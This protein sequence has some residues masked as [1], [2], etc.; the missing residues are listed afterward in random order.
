MREKLRH[1]IR[2]DRAIGFVWQA[3]SKW[4]IGSA[5]VMALQGVL[6]LA[7]LYLMKLIVDAVTEAVGAP[8]PAA[9]FSRVLLFILLAGGVA[10]L[11]ASLGAISGLIQEGL[12]LTVSDRMYDRLHAKSIEVDLDYYENPQYFDTLHRAQRE[13][14]NRPTQIVNTL[15]RLGQNS[16]SLVAMAGLLFT[17][18]WAVALVLVAA[19]APGI[20]VRMKYSRVMYHW[21]RDKTPDERKAMYYN[22]ILTGNAHAKEVRLFGIGEEISDR[23]SAVRQNLRTEKLAITRKRV[24]SDF[25]AQAFGSLAV[26][27]TFAVIAYRA[28]LGAITLGDMVM[29]YQAFQRGLGY[30]RSV[31]QGVAGLYENNLF[32]SYLYEFL[33]FEPHVRNPDAPQP[34]PAQTVQG[35][36][37]A[38]VWFRYPSTEQMVLKDI[39]FA[40]EP[41]EVVALVGE[42]GSGKTTLAK[43]LCRLY[44]PTEGQIFLENISLDRFSTAA[45]RREISV[46]FQDFAKYNLSAADNIRFGHIDLPASDIE[47][48]EKAAMDAGADR[49][50]ETLHNQ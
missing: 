6:P 1:I 26:F 25:I 13:G 37:F 47:S 35:L 45:L 42:N 11:Q 19:A 36:R 16:I 40:I 14:P 49:I 15:M 4:V 12:S 39:S 50:I 22:W 8:D 30:L 41:G 32:L 2:L 48:V 23:F 9:A 3:G 44:D 18:H 29:F 20:F 10:L 27:G 28:V 21:Q 43:L 5:A 24:I 33:D 38:H 17:F 46:I 31:L 34:V 7:A